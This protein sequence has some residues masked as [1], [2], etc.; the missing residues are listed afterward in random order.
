MA[1]F[2]AQINVPPLNLADIDGDI[3]IMGHGDYGDRVGKDAGY[4]HSARTLAKMLADGKLPTTFKGKII[5]WSCFGGISAAKSLKAKLAGRGYVNVTVWGCKYATANIAYKTFYH[6]PQSG[7]SLGE[8]G[9][10][11]YQVDVKQGTAETT[12]GDMASY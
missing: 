6:Y 11:A 8:D 2:G 1:N 7:A 10:L 5:L 9:H 3:V 12:I 4:T